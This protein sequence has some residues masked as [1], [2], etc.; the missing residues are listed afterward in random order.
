MSRILRFNSMM[1]PGR[2]PEAL[3]LV[4][5]VLK[6]ELALTPLGYPGRSTLERT[7]R[8]LRARLASIEQRTLFNEEE[9]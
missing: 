4:I 5:E 1:Y 8:E 9:P 7:I 6:A 3:K 2:D